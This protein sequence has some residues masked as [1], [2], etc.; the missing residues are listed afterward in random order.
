MFWMNNA[1]PTLFTKRLRLR[2]P[3]YSDTTDVFDFCSD[4]ASCKYADWFEHSEK[5]DTY[6][7]ICWLK[8]QSKGSKQNGYTWFVE[9]V[10]N[11][12]VIATISVMDIN[13]SQSIATVGYTLSRE[14]QHN[15]Y[16]T[17]MLLAVLKY[18]FEDMHIVRVQAKVMLQNEASVR[19]LERVGMQREGIMRKGAFCKDKC[20]DV[21]LYSILKDEFLNHNAK[22]KAFV[23]KDNVFNE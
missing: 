13:A 5:K 12:K 1:Y 7:Y 2:A 16:A 15:G 6:D 19:L 22:P 8:K 21:Y 10:D 20:V 4:P 17:E 9:L 14:Y 23:I 11:K 18:L 3:K